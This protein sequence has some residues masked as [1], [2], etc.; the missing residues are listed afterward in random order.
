MSDLLTAAVAFLTREIPDLLGVWVYGSVA[1][2]EDTPESDLDLAFLA[3]HSLTHEQRIALANE[4]MKQIGRDVDLVDLSIAPTVLR[5]EIIAYGRRI[6]CG[7][8]LSCE[9][10][11]D[12]VFADYARLN[13][14]RAEILNDIFQKGSVHG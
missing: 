11:E 10:F 7:E 14:E 12:F 3:Q 8:T 9:T 5:K 2:A 1:K 4:L 6:Y 13:E